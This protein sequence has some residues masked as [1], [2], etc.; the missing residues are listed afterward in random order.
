MEEAHLR[1][2]G[3]K[4]FQTSRIFCPKARC[5]SALTG[6][7]S[8]FGMKWLAAARDPSTVARREE[9]RFPAW[10]SARTKSP[11]AT[12]FSA[13]SR[14]WE[15]NEG[16]L[17]NCPPPMRA[18]MDGS[19]IADGFMILF[20]ICNG[21]FLRVRYRCRLKR[22]KRDG[23]PNPCQTNFQIIRVTSPQNLRPA[24]IEK[25]QTILPPVGQARSAV[26]HNTKETEGI[27]T[28]WCPEDQGSSISEQ[29]HYI[30]WFF[31]PI[32]PGYTTK[33]KI[34]SKKLEN[35]ERTGATPRSNDA[36]S[37]YSHSQIGV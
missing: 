17:A 34:A 30:L 14:T 19:A 10:N 21:Y 27:K 12:I 11:R 33:T 31:L 9:L 25:A 26:A 28:S 15:I 1:H 16:N 23:E 4:A 3:R 35:R 7:W 8:S 6:S 36:P 24:E 37:R 22:H 5:C 29:H 32:G 20:S 2:K 18:A 13:S